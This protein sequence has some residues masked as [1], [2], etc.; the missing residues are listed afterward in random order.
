[1]GHT[2][3]THLDETNMSSRLS[4]AVELPVRPS[5]RIQAAPTSL[6]S[7]KTATQ[8]TF[9][10]LRTSAPLFVSDLL[11]VVFSWSV[12]KLIGLV[13]FDTLGVPG[14]RA[15]SGL[16]AA[17]PVTFLVLGLYPGLMQHPSEELKRVVCG[18]TVAFVGLMVS[19][20]IIRNHVFAYMVNRFIHLGLLA[21]SLAVFRFVARAYFCRKKWW[22]QPVAIYG[23]EE[24][25][26]AIKNWL[27]KRFYTGLRVAESDDVDTRHAIVA[28]GSMR[29]DEG[30]L[31]DDNLLL[32]QYPTVN[33]VS[34]IGGSPYVTRKIQNCLLMPW[35]RAMKRLLDVSLV[36]LSLPFS[37][38]LLI[39]IGVL[40]KMSSKGPALY[41]HT[42]LGLNGK[43]FPAWKFRSMVLD[44]DR[45]LEEQLAND[46]EL[47]AEWEKDHKLKSDPRITPIGRIIRNTSLDELPQLWNVLTGE[48]SL[49]GPR[50]I[51]DGE[52]VKYGNVYELYKCVTPGITGL[53]QISGRNNTTYSERLAYDSYYVR[54]WSPWLDTYILIRTV[55]TVLTREGAY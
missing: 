22:R 12:A 11:A 30:D 48:M 31:S 9:Q 43:S 2:L 52:I 34:F 36:L 14:F 46:P 38:P 27:Q 18:A 41:S 32:W 51:V 15:L 49:V 37:L 47:R 6:D 29:N 20:F 44:A 53:W 16:L 7:I 39:A 10:D 42:R 45:I 8:D 26:E 54:R 5:R 3:S 35:H 33:V 25:A 40:V 4:T 50:P 13:F 55:I 19:S 21:L 24:E 17:I 28:E 1:M 23:N